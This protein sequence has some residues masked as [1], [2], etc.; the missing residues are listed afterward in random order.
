MTQADAGLE[1]GTP[2]VPLRVAIIGAGPSGFYAADALLKQ[3]AIAVEVDMFDRLPSPYGL[4]RGGVA[5]DHQKIKSV[6]K[7]YDKI[8]SHPH[9]RLYGHVEFGT[10]VTIDDLKAHY[11]QIIFA[12]GAQTDRKLGVPGE[13]LPGSYAATE[14]VAWY[15]AHPDYRQLTFDLAREKAAVIGNGNVAMDVVRILASSTDELAV[16]DIADYALDA[17]GASHITDLYILGRRGAA[18]AAFTNPE[19]KELGEMELADVIISPEDAAVDELSRAYLTAHPDPAAEKNINTM[20]LFA[21]RTPTGKPRRIHMRFLVSPV[22]LIAGPDGHVGAIKLVKNVLQAGADGSIKAKATEETEILPIDLVF[23]SIGYTGVPLP[24]IMFDKR[25]GVI[26]NKD[27]RVYDQAADAIVPNQYAVGWIKRGPSGIIGTNKPDSQA[28]VESMLADVPTL[29]ALDPALSTRESVEALLKVRK[30]T[31]TTFAD[32][33][34]ID[35]YE[36]AAGQALGRPRLK[37]SD[38]DQML[39]IVEQARQAKAEATPE[40]AAGQD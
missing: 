38:V 26:P 24:G 14:F 15:N 34:V 5:P 35:A 39:A 13:D 11:H 3:T 18:Q 21:G 30:P 23:R 19:L 37:L 17:L 2:A 36:V 20:T 7:V 10:D 28:T 25:A 8:A 29:T 40:T 32:W 33:Q 6:T 22:E 9:F 4:V 16:T 27:G 1:I 12:V 31:Y